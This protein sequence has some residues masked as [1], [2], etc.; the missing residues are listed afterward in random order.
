MIVPLGIHL[1]STIKIFS[2]ILALNSVLWFWL[3]Y[4]KKQ[5]NSYL[6]IF[7][8]ENYLPKFGH[9]VKSGESFL[10]HPVQYSMVLTANQDLNQCLILISVV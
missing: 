1:V 8:V 2:R 7:K 10:N 6:K 5:P 4:N 3:L 9:L